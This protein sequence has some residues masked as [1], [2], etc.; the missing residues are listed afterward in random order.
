M[1]MALAMCRSC[2]V[3]DRDIRD[4]ATEIIRQVRLAPRN[5][6]Y[7]A[8]FRVLKRAVARQFGVPVRSLP[9]RLD[10]LKAAADYD[11]ERAKRDEWQA[12]DG[13]PWGHAF[14]VHSRRFAAESGV[15]PRCSRRGRFTID[16]GRCGC[17]FR[18][19]RRIDTPRRTGRDAR[20]AR[21]SRSV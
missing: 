9:G 8:A 19:G 5:K 18:Y 21:S 16:T 1:A 15:C 20:Q 11:A 6:R 14:D 3:R 2:S 13:Q 17:G 7:A 4:V 12:R 10:E